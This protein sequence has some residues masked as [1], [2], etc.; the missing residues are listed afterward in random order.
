LESTLILN[1]LFKL[2]MYSPII[3]SAAYITAGVRAFFRS[4]DYC[5]TRKILVGVIGI[6]GF[7]IC[8]IILKLLPSISIEIL[9]TI[10]T[11][12][13]KVVTTLLL[14]FSMIYYDEGKTEGL[15]ALGYFCGFIVITNIV[16]KI[17][18]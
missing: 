11:R 4:D 10:I 12:F 8:S 6:V 7:I 1:F 17:F 9:D 18:T 16:E 15:Q 5:F 14:L 13:M 3:V 2:F